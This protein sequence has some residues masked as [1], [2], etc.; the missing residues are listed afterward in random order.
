[1]NGQMFSTLYTVFILVLLVFMLV[2]SYNIIKLGKKNKVVVEALQ[3]VADETE[4]DE[5]IDQ[6]QKTADEV[7]KNKLNVI[8][9]WGKAFHKHAEEYDNILE[10]TNLDYLFREGKNGLTIE[11]NED[12]FFYL[13]LAIPNMLYGNGL[14]EERKK[15]WE[16]LNTKK[17]LL[18]DQ[19]V[20]KIGE[21]CEKYYDGIG[22]KGQSFFEKVLEGDYG[23]FKYTKS[24]IGLYKE[25]CTTMLYKIYDEKNDERKEECKPTVELFA[26]RGVGDRWLHAM[27]IELEKEEETEEKIEEEKE[28]A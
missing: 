20:V 5:F 27:N 19:L 3:K 22:D 1:M 10:D 7:V 11:S 18:D 24:L 16:K 17:D 14:N 9:L 21:A 6:N 28:E 4:F 8:K 12:A 15:V 13:S 23:E 25:I 26:T 2:R